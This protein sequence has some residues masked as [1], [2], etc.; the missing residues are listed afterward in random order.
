MY[1]EGGRSIEDP[2]KFFYLKEDTGEISQQPFDMIVREQVFKLL[3]F[4]GSFSSMIITDYF[5]DQD[6]QKDKF[7]FG[8]SHK[9]PFYFTYY[10][11]S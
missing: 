5:Q 9:V 10:S 6:D 11:C 2:K 4:K 1:D 8:A 7:F 3:K